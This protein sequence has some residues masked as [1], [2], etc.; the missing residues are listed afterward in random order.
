MKT[1]DLYN[2]LYEIAKNCGFRI[3]NERGNFQSGYCILN[4]DKLIIFNRHTTMETKAVVL[5]RCIAAEDYENH[6]M[7]PAIR[8]YIEKER[9]YIS[10]LDNVKFDIS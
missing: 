3:R 8:D 10:K 5:A 4:E 7:K 1:E 2:E 6:Y 9:N